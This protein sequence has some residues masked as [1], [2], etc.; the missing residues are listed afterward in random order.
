MADTV[1]DSALRIHGGLIERI[2]ATHEKSSA[3][4]EDVKQD[5]ALALWRA[6]PTW[7]GDC[8]LRTFVARVTHNVCIDHVRRMTRQP[9]REELDT[10]MQS[11]AETPEEAAV[12][13][14]VGRRLMEEVTSLPP[15]LRDVA[16]LMLEDFS[17]RE[18][19]D[20]LG[21]SEGTVATR[22]TR[23]RASLRE[24]LKDE[25]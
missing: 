4:R 11:D 5:V 21:L 3:S 22:A 14:D 20:T 24:R 15:T 7:R 9:R 10:D 23:A 19:A 1:F 2:I 18:I 6:A 8:S 13:S 16:V 17:T 12:R 25:L